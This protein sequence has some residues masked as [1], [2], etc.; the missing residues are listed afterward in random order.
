MAAAGQGVCGEG[1]PRVAAGEPRPRAQQLPARLLP[2]VR[3]LRLYRLAGGP[4]GR[5]VR[6]ARQRPPMACLEGHEHCEEGT[7]FALKAGGCHAA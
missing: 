6:S 5:S 4:A 7:A 3:R 2:A 1:G